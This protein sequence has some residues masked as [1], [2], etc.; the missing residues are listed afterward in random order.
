MPQNQIHRLRYEEDATSN[1]GTEDQALLPSE[2][3]EPA[4]S[5]T[6]LADWKRALSRHNPPPRRAARHFGGVN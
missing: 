1:M 2:Y 5:P 4:R 3:A 6:I